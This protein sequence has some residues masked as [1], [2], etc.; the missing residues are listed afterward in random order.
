MKR[1]RDTRTE[2]R[3]REKISRLGAENLK[4]RELIAAIIGRG[5][6]GRDVGTISSDIEKILDK[7]EGHPEMSDL[8][9]IDGIGLCGASQIIAAFELSRRYREDETKKVTCP[10]DVLPLVDYI[11]NKTQ[12]YFICITLNGAGEV[13]KSRVVTIGLLNQSP[14]H[15]RE[16]FSDAITDRC[17]SVIFVHNHP[18]GNPEPSVQDK[19]ITDRLCTAGE[20]LGIEVLDH[21]IVS[22]KDYTSFKQRGLL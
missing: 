6:R 10:E 5:I 21:L 15:P 14:V 8:M 18:S 17:A 7:N 13:I 20:I 9:S 22:K 19:D 11:R 16:V 2:D 1:I 4:N 12:E 3:P